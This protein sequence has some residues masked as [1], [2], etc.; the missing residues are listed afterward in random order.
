[1]DV[2]KPLSAGEK[3]V[4]FDAPVLVTV[5]I[6]GADGDFNKSELKR[7][8]ELAHD[9]KVTARAD[10]VDFYTIVGEGIED[11]LKV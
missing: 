8:V 7:A 1:M 9:R 11:K 10:L 5:L 2:L 6:A 3:D 4:L